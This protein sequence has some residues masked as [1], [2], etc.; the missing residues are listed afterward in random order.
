MLGPFGSK[1]GST[2]KRIKAQRNNAIM[3]P[4]TAILAGLDP[5]A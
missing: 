5:T 3:K 2:L 1:F 4:A